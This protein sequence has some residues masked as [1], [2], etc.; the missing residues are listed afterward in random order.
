MYYMINICVLRMLICTSRT[1]T[2]HITYHYNYAHVGTFKMGGEGGA[3]EEGRGKG[4]IRSC[5]AKC[6][7][8]RSRCVCEKDSS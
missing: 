7:K 1:V 2:Y 5:S 6:F 8:F 3:G 4:G